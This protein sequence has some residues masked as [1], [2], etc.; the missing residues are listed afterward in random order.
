ME[1][2][3]KYSD[4]AGFVQAKTDEKNTEQREKKNR[5]TLVFHL[6]FLKVTLLI[7]I[8]TMSCKVGKCLTK[9]AKYEGG[10]ESVEVTR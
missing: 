4:S 2:K 8:D 6:N 9:A 5:V 3:Q 1:I 7:Q 10:T